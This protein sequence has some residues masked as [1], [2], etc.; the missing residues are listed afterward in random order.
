LLDAE[1]LSGE[2]QR[3]S[4]KSFAHRE[5]QEDPKHSRCNA[6]DVSSHP[7]EHAYRQRS[8]GEVHY[9]SCPFVGA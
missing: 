9:I 3:I 4:L 8:G 7:K 6:G 2:Y 1:E 5:E